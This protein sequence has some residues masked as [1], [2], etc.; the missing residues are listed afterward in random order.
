MLLLMVNLF[1]VQMK[2]WLQKPS[3]RHLSQ[4][5]VCRVS[6]LS[7]STMLCLPHGIPG[8]QNVGADISDQ[9]DWSRGQASEQ[10]T[11]RNRRCSCQNDLKDMYLS[12]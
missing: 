3:S 2:G 7:P 8:R 5:H 9:A 12:F 10:G 1:C 4:I 11:D 6:C